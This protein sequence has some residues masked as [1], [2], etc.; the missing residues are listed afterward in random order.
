V[1]EPDVMLG[2]IVCIADDEAG[3]EVVDPATPESGDAFF[4][5][6]RASAGN[7]GRTGLGTDSAGR[8][9]TVEGTDCLP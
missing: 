1:E 6:L 2:S 3:R 4:Y 8:P 5:L 7:L 9:R